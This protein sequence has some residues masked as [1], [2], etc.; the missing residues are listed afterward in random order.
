MNNKHDG[1]QEIIDE[2]LGSMAAEAV[3]GFDPQRCNLAEFCRRTGL[4]RRRAGTIKANGFKIRLP[5][6]VASCWPRA[7]TPPTIDANPDGYTV[8]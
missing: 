1:L 5:Y 2:T 3:G 8:A 4:S 7:L 6:S